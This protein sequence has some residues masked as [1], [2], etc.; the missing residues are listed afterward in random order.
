MALPDVWDAFVL[1]LGI[2]YQN[3]IT[4][5]LFEAHSD[6]LFN[7]EFNGEDVIITRPGTCYAHPTSLLCTAKEYRGTRYFVLTECVCTREH[8]CTRREA[9]CPNAVS[10]TEKENVGTE[11]E[12]TFVPGVEPTVV[13]IR[14]SVLRKSMFCTRSRGTQ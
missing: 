5:Q 1:T 9:V 13:R 8:G 3:I 4:E 2:C 7:T 12:S 14:C 11:R 10:L 6:M